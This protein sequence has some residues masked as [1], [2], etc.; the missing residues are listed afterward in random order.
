[1]Q[2][3]GARQQY[4]P[5]AALNR[6]GV[7]RVANLGGPADRDQDFIVSPARPMSTPVSCRV[8]QKSDAEIALR[9]MADLDG[10]ATVHRALRSKIQLVAV[11]Q[12]C[13]RF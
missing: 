2:S 9:T 7:H 10:L 6:I 3:P 8:Y 5:S 1:M 13:Y 4:P 12:A 11:D